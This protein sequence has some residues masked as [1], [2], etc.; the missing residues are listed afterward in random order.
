MP[1]VEEVIYRLLPNGSRAGRRSWDQCP[2]WPPDV[3]A[4]VATLTKLSECYSHARYAC[5]LKST[6][7]RTETWFYDSTYIKEMAQIGEQWRSSGARPPA[8]VDAL[9][10]CIIRERKRKVTALGGKSLWDSVLKLLAITDEASR[11]IGFV[12]DTDQYPFA[13]YWFFEHYRRQFHHKPTL[14]FPHSICSLVSPE[15]VCVQ[16]KTR[17]SQV[18]CTLRSLTHHLALLPSIG[19][20]KTSWTLA[21]QGPYQECHPLNLLLVPFPYRIH[22]NAFQ[23]HENGAYKSSDPTFFFSINQ[24]WLREGTKPIGVRSITDFLLDLITQ[25]EREVADVHGVILPE[26]ALSP[27]LA[28]RIAHALAKKNKRLEIFI[29]GVNGHSENRTFERNYIYATIFYQSGDE[30]TVIPWEQGKHHRWKLEKDQIKRYHLGHVLNPER[31]WWERIDIADRRCHFYVF[32]HG[33]TLATLICEDLARIEPVQAVLRSVGPNLVVA[34]LMDGPQLERR[35]PGRYATVLADD[36]GSAVLTLTSLG[37][38]RRSCMPGDKDSRQ[39]ALW[40]DSSGIA[41]E[42]SL[43]EGSHGLL[44]TI[45]S[46]WENNWTFDRRPD[47]DRTLRLALSGVRSVRHSNPPRW[48][49]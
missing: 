24:T 25:A 46:S 14:R 33:A 7:G 38:A 30:L 39:I 5:A 34:L 32:R 18:G 22:G 44:L 29:S 48:L 3:F 45:S 19:E 15:E 23:G 49:D 20:V 1:T 4:V 28:P 16:P 37:M 35:W 41:Q 17:T 42:L 36:P 6:V 2:I 40:K 27:E 8:E 9:W 13:D 26:G 21:S 43:P 31:T 11:G 12:T 47:G 10:R